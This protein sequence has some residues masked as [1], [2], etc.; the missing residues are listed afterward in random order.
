VASTADLVRDNL[1]LDPAG[2]EHLMRLVRAWSLLADLSFADLLLF[3]PADHERRLLVGQVRPTTAQTIHRDDLVGDELPE[4]SRRIVR[5]AFRTGHITKGR[6]TVGPIEAEVTAIPVRHD[7]RVIAV[8]T[9]DAAPAMARRPSDLEQTYLRVFDRLARMVDAGIYPF[10]R[11]Q[12]DLYHRPRVGDGVLVLDHLMRVSYNSPNAVSTLHRLGVHVNAAGLTLGELG[13]DDAVVRTAELTRCPV[14]AELDRKAE[15][16]VA[17]HCTPLIDRNQVTGA[18]V[19]V[20]DISELRR[21]DRML[22][23]KD[24]T[25]REIHHR[26]KNNLQTI[27]SLLRLQARRLTSVEAKEAVEESVRRITAIAV[28]HES[29][30]HEVGNEAP[31]LEIVRPLA[32]M[33]EDALSSPEHP[34][35]ITLVG[36]AGTLPANVATSLA[37]VITELLQ[38]AVGHAYPTDPQGE[39][40]EVAGRVVVELAR[41]DSR[42][43]IRVVDDG[44]GVVEGFSLDESAGL[45]LTIARTFIE[46][47]LGGSI[48]IRARRDGPGTVVE[49]SVPVEESA[50]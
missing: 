22:V 35:H 21:R 40:S 28:V 31:L 19:L 9:R 33:V 46:H 20:R 15:T 34:I 48:E 18:L 41:A 25:I 38:N 6:V 45:G 30:S 29:L 32:R 16:T 26:V 12:E 36:D 44:V 43:Q 2:A 50:T 14:F 3:L 7:G 17:V 42:V 24:A 1:P 37:L 27:S 4:G 49:L 11:E 13:L 39:R 10:P 8:M 47:D 23:S 5:T